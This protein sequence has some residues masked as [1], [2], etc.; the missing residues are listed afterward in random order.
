M[1]AINSLE[2]LFPSVDNAASARTDNQLAQQDFFKLMVAQLE[3]QDP[4]DPIDNGEFLAQMAQF[5]AVDGIYGLQAS[6]NSLADTMQ[7]NQVADAAALLGRDVLF[8]GG[9]ASLATGAGLEG[10]VVT[11]A[12]ATGV[13]LRIMDASGTTVATRSLGNLGAGSNAFQWDGTTSD[14]Q[15]VQAGQYRVS[16][17]G[18]INGVEQ[19]LPVK[20]YGRVDSVG[21]DPLS[22]EL[23]LQLANGASLS[24]SDVSEFK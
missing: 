22:R 10:Q 5:S 8:D 9:S 23:S 4:S 19:S 13:T 17:T 18:A 11:A 7:R 20:L 21:V 6:F 14:G 1:E 2:G 12:A 24:L 16:I 3:N 15:A